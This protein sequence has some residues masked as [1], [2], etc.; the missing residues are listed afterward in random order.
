MSPIYTLV[1]PSDTTAKDQLLGYQ[2][3]VAGSMSSLY[4]FPTEPVSSPPILWPGS[5]T[6]SD[7]DGKSIHNPT[8]P[9]R[10]DPVKN[11]RNVSTPHHRDK[12]TEGPEEQ[13]P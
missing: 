12:P 6:G 2:A 11:S 10:Q 13:G 1:L 9:M 5:L 8:S 4:D 3:S 7:L